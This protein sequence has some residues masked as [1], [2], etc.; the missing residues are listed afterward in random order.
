MKTEKELEPIPL[1]ELNSNPLVSVLMANYNYE[2][3]IGEA[4]ESVI[5]QT[6]TN[7]ELVICDD[8][9]T[10]NSVEI[11]EEYINKDTRIKLIKKENNGIVS[12]YNAGYKDCKGDIICLLDSDDY[13]TATK[14]EKV[15]R[16]FI[17]NPNCGVHFH[18]MMRTNENGKPEGKYPLISK[19]PNGWLAHEVLK[20]GGGMANISPTSGIS[21]RKEVF[22]NILPINFYISSNVDAFIINVSLILSPVVSNMEILCYYRLHNQNLSNIAN[23]EITITEFINRKKKEIELSTKIFRVVNNWLEQNN[24]RQR[25]NELQNNWF[26]LESKYIICKLSCTKREMKYWLNKLLMHPL[27][28]SH[29]HVYIFYKV[30]SLLNISLLKYLLELKYGQGKLKLFINKLLMK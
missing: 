7:L 13:Y 18:R 10:D 24:Y 8:G 19:I 12:A 15:V 25:L 11:I 30:S 17:C 26:I 6:Y 16:D 2:K 21:L 28:K 5:N 14:I 3:F 4:I 9:S 20:L 1:N 23:K 22:K 29:R 27:T